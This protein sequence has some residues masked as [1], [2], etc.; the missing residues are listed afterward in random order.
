MG[1]NILKI[2]RLLYTVL[3]GISAVTVIS[4]A[5]FI[6]SAYAED[7]ISV[8]CYNLEK[9]PH[10]LGNVVVYDPY[11]AAMAC[12]SVYY[13][14]KGRCVGCFSDSDYLDVVCADASGTIFL[15]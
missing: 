13:E 7:S 1:K 8:S 11:R 14:C 10:I 5:G 2:R 9:S 15:K 6:A 3:L 4:A 12:N